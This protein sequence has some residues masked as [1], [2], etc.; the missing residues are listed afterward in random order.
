[1]MGSPPA[2]AGR[3]PACPSLCCRRTVHPRLRGE[4]DSVRNAIGGGSGQPPPV[5]GRLA[6]DDAHKELT[7]FTPAREGRMNEDEAKWVR[8]I[9]SP[10]PTRGRPCCCAVRSVLCRCTPACA[11]KTTFR[12]RKLARATGHPREYGE[13]SL[14]LGDGTIHGGSP[15]CVWGRRAFG[16]AHE[17]TRWLTPACAGEYGA[18]EEVL[19]IDSG[20]PTPARGRP[21]WRWRRQSGERPTHA[22]TW[23]TSSTG[24]SAWR[25]TVHPRLHGED[26][27]IEQF[28]ARDYGSPPPAR[29]RL[30][31]RHRRVRV[32]GLT[33]ACTGKTLHSKK[34]SGVRAA[35]PRL[36]GE[37]ATNSALKRGVLGSPPPARGRL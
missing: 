10:P 11:G 9:G 5:R 1:M 22:C 7:A 36:H 15:P 3:T 21:F 18:R 35:H 26:L 23:K 24:R 19:R 4:N 30:H 2:C 6:L 12:R 27:D 20:S 13:D 31:L 25:S 29:G 34:P 16:L 37:D 33:P 28:Q 8:W 17:S 14:P 32:V